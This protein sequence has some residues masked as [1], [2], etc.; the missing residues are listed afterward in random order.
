MVPNATATA[1]NHLTPVL[2]AI[3]FCRPFQ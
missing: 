1:K 3:G 2:N